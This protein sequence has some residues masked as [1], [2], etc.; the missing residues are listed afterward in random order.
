MAWNLSEEMEIRIC[1][2][3]IADTIGIEI[4]T[5][6]TVLDTRDALLVWD[7]NERNTLPKDL[8]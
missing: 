3:T 7:R 5:L 2:R 8:D 6:H 1:I 4:K